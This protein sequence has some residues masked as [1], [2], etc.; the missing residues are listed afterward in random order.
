M[1]RVRTIRRH[2]L[3]FAA[4]MTL[5]LCLHA[6]GVHA[7]DATA[8]SDPLAAA[9]MPRPYPAIPDYFPYFMIPSGRTQNFE[10][11][12]EVPS[13]DR[14][15]TPGLSPQTPQQTIKVFQTVPAD[16]AL[17]PAKSVVT[18][19]WLPMDESVYE[20]AAPNQAQIP[21]R[22]EVIIT[23]HN[24]WDFR[25]VIRVYPGKR[26]YTFLFNP[27][28]PGRYQWHVRAI[29]DKA[30]HGFNSDRRFFMVLP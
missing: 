17:F 2:A 22:Y 19:G 11:P 8:V 7:L 29:Y 20:D 25:Q 16:D 14:Y 6:P 23:R 27:P 15:P 12:L 21:I 24:R 9:L 3:L 1:D 18:L 4:T 10:M 5:A 13:V 28:G 26:H 30:M